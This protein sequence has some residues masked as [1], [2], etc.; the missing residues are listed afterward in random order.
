MYDLA[1]IIFFTL[2]VFSAG[3]LVGYPAG[4]FFAQLEERPRRS[5]RKRRNS[6]ADDVLMAEIIE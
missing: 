5:R 3:F 1:I 6:A 4:S 2:G